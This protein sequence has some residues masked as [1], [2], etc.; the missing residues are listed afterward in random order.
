MELRKLDV[1][2][3]AEKG[4]TFNIVDA[5]GVETDLAI[6]VVGAGSRVF[7]LEKAK[8]DQIIANAQQRR[9]PLSDEE[10]S[11]LWCNLLAKCTTGWEN[12]ELDGKVLDFSFDN[13]LRIYTEFPFIRSQVLEKIYDIKGLLENL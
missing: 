5:Y 4:V 6:S 1:L 12:L 13:A 10:E 3:A 7:K 11:D 8:N 9:K 2:A